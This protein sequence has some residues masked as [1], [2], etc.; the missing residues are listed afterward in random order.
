MVVMFDDD[1]MNNAVKASDLK[2]LP[3]GSE[4]LESEKSE[5]SNPSSSKPKTY[6]SFTCSQDSLS[7]FSNNPIGFKGKL[8]DIIIAKLRRGQVTSTHPKFY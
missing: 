2:W 8:G 5:K 7:E 1:A 4:F 3:N 6:T